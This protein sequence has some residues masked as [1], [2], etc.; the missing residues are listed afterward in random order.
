MPDKNTL[1][2]QHQFNAAIARY[3]GGRGYRR[4]ELAVSLLVLVGQAALWARSLAAPTGWARGLAAFALAYLL[5]DFL[6]GLVHLLMDHVGRYTGWSGPLVAAFH[7]HH[8][9]P[10]YQERP[11]WAVYFHESGFKLWLPPFLA[12]VLALSWRPGLPPVA[13]RALA[14]MGL[15]SSVAEVSHYL[16]H[17]SPSRTARA[18]ARAGLL[19]DK[20]AHARHHREDNVSYAFLNGWSNPLLD[21]LARLLFRGYKQGTDLHFAAWEPNGVERAGH[22]TASLRGK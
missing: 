3:Q 5:T 13:L 20:R 7:L 12:I 6:N 16:C 8:R 15:L 18:L 17:N 11:L 9:T 22:E 2:K 10:R 14:W 4:L 1:L 21:L 19:L